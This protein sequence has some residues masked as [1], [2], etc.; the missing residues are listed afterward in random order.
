VT[1]VASDSTL[2]AFDVEVPDA[3]T[4]GQSGAAGVAVVT[5]RRDHAHAMVANPANL[6]L[7]GTAAASGSDD[8]TVSGLD[9]TY[10]T[11][12]VELADIVPSTDGRYPLFRVG[13]G[14][15]G[16]P[17]INSGGTDYAYV[18]DVFTDTSTSAEIQVSTGA[19]AISWA[20]SG[21][22]SASGEGLGARLEIHRPG[23]ASIAPLITGH[24]VYNYTDGNLRGN[25]IFAQRTAVI[26][27]TQVRFQF[28]SGTTASG[29]MTVWGMAHG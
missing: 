9:S 25:I 16:T 29:R 13:T 19:N 2:L 21:V 22:G 5:S 20:H 23:D 10:D 12:I 7:I 26:T 3:I 8:L 6:A 17:V 24:S 28:N 11:Y 18:L 1:A 27:L 4:F 15:A 14:T